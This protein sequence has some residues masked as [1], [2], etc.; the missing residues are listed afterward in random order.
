MTPPNQP[1]DPDLLMSHAAALRGLARHLVADEHAAEDVVQE[2]LALALER[3]PREAS[4]LAGWLRVSLRHVAFKRKRAESGRSAREEAAARPEELPSTVTLVEHRA[5]L[6]G[7]AGALLGLHEPYQTALF[8]RYF[9]D[10]PP[11]AISARLGV[12]EATI[13]SRLHRG[14]SL[15]R[16]RLDERHDGG[17][18]AWAGVAL[19]WSGDTAKKGILG[20][21]GG[22]LVAKNI[23]VVAVGVGLVGL[24]VWLGRA[25]PLQEPETITPFEDQ[26]ADLNDEREPL[27]PPPED[28]ESPPVRP[29]TPMGGR[30]GDANRESLA[31]GGTGAAP[32]YSK[33]ADEE[34]LPPP[35]EIIETPPLAAL[36][37]RLTRVFDFSTNLKLVEMNLGEL[38]AATPVPDVA[39]MDFQLQLSRNLTVLD[40]TG[41]MAAPYEMIRTYSKIENKVSTSVDES[42]EG[43]GQVS[44][45]NSAGASEVEGAVVGFLSNPEQAERLL[46]DGSRE[47]MD[48]LA[49]DLMGG[50]LRRNPPIPGVERSLKSADLER[51]LRP[52][53]DLRVRYEEDGYPGDGFFD[54]WGRDANSETPKLRG[55][56][57]VTGVSIEYDDTFELERVQFSFELDTSWTRTLDMPA[58]EG[59][60][61]DVRIRGRRLWSGSGEY[62]WDTSLEYMRS[63]TLEGEVEVTSRVRASVPDA[64]I[65][66]DVV[67]RYTG[68]SQFTLTTSP[69]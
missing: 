36:P 44:T 53:G 8:L 52:G 31:S 4:G 48:G 21:L 43:A 61:E 18:A 55:S 7:V 11:R 57:T 35:E 67:T 3:P 41:S 65:D 6:E 63:V 22:L 28:A 9:E 23:A 51:L 13:K 56:M 42:A 27:E 47:P 50:R 49:R 59:Q 66:V 24:L 30:P 62:L 34:L 29:P 25:G 32:A 1:L 60:L 16:E 33:P 20:T 37:E 39:E 2:T 15:L 69:D 54:P 68:D 46:E 64:E 12:N 40:V 17:R 10:L 19:A 38:E 26:T 14:L 45:W 58:A 5:L